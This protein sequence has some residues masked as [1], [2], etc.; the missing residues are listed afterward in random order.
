VQQTIADRPDG[1]HPVRLPFVEIVVP[2]DS[3]QFGRTPFPTR[4]TTRS[5]FPVLDGDVCCLDVLEAD[6]LN[7]IRVGEIAVHMRGAGC[8]CLLPLLRAQIIGDSYDGKDCGSARFEDPV[9]GSQHGELVGYSTEDVGARHRIEGS[10][11]EGE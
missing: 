4:T 7:Q 8:D 11:G 3:S 10:I 6:D 1:T 5:R 9:A 2:D